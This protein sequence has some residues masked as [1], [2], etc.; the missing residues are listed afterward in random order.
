MR[1]LRWCALGFGVGGLAALFA[2]AHQTELPLVKTADIA[3]S[4]NYGHIRIQGKVVTA[5]RVFDNGGR[6][7]YISFDVD[8]GSGRIT[9]AASRRTARR[10]VSESKVPAQGA[11]IEVAGSLSLAPERRPRLYLDTPSR[12]RPLDE[13]PSSGPLEVRATRPPSAAKGET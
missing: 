10:L 12:L 11:R 5:P 2:V 1:I 4:M 13:A 3:P 9:V 8:D 6:P 7:D